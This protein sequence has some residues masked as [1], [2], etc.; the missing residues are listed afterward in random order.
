MSLK[1]FVSRI[2]SASAW[3]VGLVFFR[4]FM[5]LRFASSADLII[6]RMNWRAGKE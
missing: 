5:G 2:T 4:Y 3:G 6:L 1:T